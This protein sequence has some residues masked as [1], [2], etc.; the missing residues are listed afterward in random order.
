[1]YLLP[2]R[3]P[4]RDETAGVGTLALA[5]ACRLHPA[6]E[7]GTRCSRSCSESRRSSSSSSCSNE[8]YKKCSR[9]CGRDCVTEEKSGKIFSKQ[10]SRTVAPGGY[11]ARRRVPHASSKPSAIE[12]SSLSSTSSVTRATIISHRRL[13]LAEIL[14]DD[15][16]RMHA[17]QV[18]RHSEFSL[19]SISS[20]T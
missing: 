14:Q 12:K 3:S 8:G 16:C 1:M 6:H 4:G 5:N 2:R 13:H 9:S 10:C 17:Q 15:A 7:R 18:Q 20:A 11:L 19:S